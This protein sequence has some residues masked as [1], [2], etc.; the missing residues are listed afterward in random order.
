MHC[1]MDLVSY[2]SYGIILL[3]IW[4]LCQDK[5]VQTSYGRHM[6]LSTQTRTIPAKLA[7][8]VQGMACLMILLLLLLTQHKPSTMGKYLLL[9]M[10]GIHYFHR[11]FIYS[12]LTRGQAFPLCVMVRGSMF[13]TLNSFVQGHYLLHCAEFEDR[14]SADYRFKIGCVMFYV[15]MAINIHSDFILRNLRKSGEVLYKIPRGG[16]FEYVSSANYFGEIVEWFGFAIATWS[17]SALSFA[18]FSLCFVGPRAYYH[19]RFYIEKFRDYPKSRKALI[20]F[21]C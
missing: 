14:W 6:K 7:W 5:R 8:F 9:G 1:C 18:V 16:L 2:L 3:G 20:P 11:T 13:C 17:L 21:I 4:H 12:L 10:F 15:G 19:H